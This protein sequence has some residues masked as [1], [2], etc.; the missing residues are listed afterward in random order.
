MSSILLPL[1]LHISNRVRMLRKQVSIPTDLHVLCQT[2]NASIQELKANGRV[3]RRER[4]D[5]EL[6]ALPQLPLL[7]LLLR[8]IPASEPI[9]DRIRMVRNQM[10]IPTHAALLHPLASTHYGPTP[11]STAPCSYTQSTACPRSA[12]SGCSPPAEASLHRKPAP[13]ATSIRRL[14][15]SL[16]ARRIGLG[17]RVGGRVGEQH[18]VEKQVDLGVHGVARQHGGAR[19]AGHAEA[20]GRRLAVGGRGKTRIV[21]VGGVVDALRILR[22]RV[23]HATTRAILEGPAHGPDDGRVKERVVGGFVGS[24]IWVFI[25]I[26]G[27]MGVVVCVERAARFQWKR[28]V[29]CRLRQ[30]PQIGRPNHSSTG[31]R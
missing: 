14:R 12:R 10:P 16:G 31:G 30:F 4:V 13:H 21:R 29:C 3:A 20:I 9:C 28:I 7:D 18:L 2:T 23:E 27:S 6:V 25:W 17:E 26:A 24:F 19:M 5:L 1:L 8:Q 15:R 11:R 22:E